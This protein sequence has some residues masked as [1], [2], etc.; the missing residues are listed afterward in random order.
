MHLLIILKSYVKFTILFF[1][2]ST[3]NKYANN[4]GDDIME[5]NN[6]RDYT[7]SNSLRNGNKSEGQYG[8]SSFNNTIEQPALNKSG[9]EAKKRGF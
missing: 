6:K 1:I 9:L 5:N 4:K 3:N 2:N 8:K 7:K